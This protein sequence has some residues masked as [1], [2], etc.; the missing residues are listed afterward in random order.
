MEYQLNEGGGAP[1]TLAVTPRPSGA[2]VAQEVRRT[3]SFA[4]GAASAVSP[5]HCGPFS[6][7][8]M[9]G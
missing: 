2:A 1:D 7:R 5:T 6:N 3:L 8:Q 4:A 9:R